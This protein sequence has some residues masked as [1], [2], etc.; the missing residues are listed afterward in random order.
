[1][2][3]KF[4]PTV[5]TSLHFTYFNPLGT[6]ERGA[7]IVTFLIWTWRT[8]NVI[9]ISLLT[10]NCRNFYPK[11][12]CTRKII[13]ISTISSRKR[14]SSGIYI[15]IY[16]TAIGA[17]WVYYSFNLTYFSICNADH[18]YKNVPHNNFVLTLSLL[19]WWAQFSYVYDK[20]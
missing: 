10:R 13:K 6:P 19:S 11:K 3:R 16:M 9:K 1:M 17:K 8:R 7:K 18:L 14:Q 5:T 4:C 20:N 2:D 12:C 15:Y